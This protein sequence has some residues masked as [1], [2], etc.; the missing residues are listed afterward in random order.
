MTADLVLQNK[1]E[2][3]DFNIELSGIEI[4]KFREN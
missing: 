4:S 3:I 2:T 1:I